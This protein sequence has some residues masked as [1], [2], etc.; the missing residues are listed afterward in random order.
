MALAQS[1]VTAQG[2]TSVPAAIRRRL[3]IGPGA[4]LEWDEEDG[5]VIVRAK[6]YSFEDMRKKLFGDTPVKPHTLEEL[7]EGIAQYM[8]ETHGRR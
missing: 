8:R 3:G 6:R 5:K 7:T 1:K 4:I 2:K